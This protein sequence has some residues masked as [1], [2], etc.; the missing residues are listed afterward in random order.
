[1]MKIKRKNRIPSVGPVRSHMEIIDDKGIKPD[2]TELKVVDLK[3][4][5]ERKAKTSQNIMN[6]KIITSLK[7]YHENV[8][9]KEKLCGWNVE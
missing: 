3:S 9:G 6:R 7:R 1:M 2:I 4:R 5:N 8:Q